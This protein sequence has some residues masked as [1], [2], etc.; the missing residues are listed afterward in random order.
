MDRKDCWSPACVPGTLTRVCR[1]ASLNK[2]HLQLEGTPEPD[3]FSAIPR[4]TGFLQDSNGMAV[5]FTV[6]HVSHCSDHV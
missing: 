1:I 5:N 3:T 2:Q 6:H 4:V